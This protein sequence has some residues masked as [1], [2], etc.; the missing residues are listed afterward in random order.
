MT[1]SLSVEILIFYTAGVGIRVNMSSCRTF[2]DLVLSLGKNLQLARKHGHLPFG[3]V[4][5]EVGSCITT[6]S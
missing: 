4:A 1:F 2:V 3:N 5:D 6:V